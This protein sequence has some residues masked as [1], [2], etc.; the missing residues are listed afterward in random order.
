MRT[1]ILAACLFI[2]PFVALAA[3]ETHFYG[4]QGQYR[5]RATTDAANPQQKSLYTRD[6]KYI[7]RA[8]TGSDGTVRIY[9]QHG[10]YR[11]RT[12]ERGQN[13]KR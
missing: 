10:N 6:G 7:G 13:I 5:G 11:G 8:M 12:S 9:D 4:P 2:L 1:T 3:E